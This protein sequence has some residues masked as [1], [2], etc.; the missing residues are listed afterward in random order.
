MLSGERT[1]K[2]SSNALY[3][4]FA[5][6]IGLIAQGLVRVDPMVTHRFSLGD[7][8]KAFETACNKAQSQAIKIIL[9]CEL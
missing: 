2:T 6:A 7:G 5:R 4:D 9:G 8:I 3:A 1:I